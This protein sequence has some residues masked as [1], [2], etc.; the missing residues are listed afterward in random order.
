MIL[1]KLPGILLS[2][3]FFGCSSIHQEAWENTQIK[4]R[5]HGITPLS[6]NL[7]HRPHPSSIHRGQVL[8]RKHCL[9]CHGALGDGQGTGTPKGQ[10]PADLRTLAK[11]V[12]HFKFFLSISQWQGNM[13]GWEEPLNE[14]DR[15]DLA[16]YIKFLGTE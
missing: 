12:R 8:Y 9:S 7:E 10:S 1:L 15:E 13:P 6:A 14:L 5:G 16:A 11:R 4:M 2:L 3:L